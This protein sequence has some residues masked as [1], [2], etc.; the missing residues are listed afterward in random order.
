[1]TVTYASTAWM[2]D[3][4]CAGIPDFTEAEVAEQR[5]ICNRCPVRDQCLDYALQQDIP[6]HTYT[7]NYAG[8]S[9]ADLVKVAHGADADTE[10]VWCGARFI[11][12]NS[13]ALYCSRRCGN[14]AY[15]ARHA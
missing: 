7:T 1:M 9:A 6:N 10:C 11:G 5:P 4:A 13:L 8:L 2:M 15:K 14:A 3:A 12:G